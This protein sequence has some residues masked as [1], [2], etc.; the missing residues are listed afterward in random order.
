MSAEQRDAVRAKWG[1][2][3]EDLVIGCVAN[4]R[5]VKALDLLV[6]A[7]EDVVAAKANA[8]LVLVGEGPERSRLE[9]MVESAGL[10]SRVVLHGRE[11]DGGRLQAAFDI[12][13]LTS[14]SEG[15][16]NAMLEAE[17]AG[18]P[19]VATDVGGMREVVLDEVT[20]LLVSS[21]DRTALAL[22]LVRLAD[23]PSLRER[24][25][26]AGRKHVESAFGM[27]RFVREFSELYRELAG[28]RARSAVDG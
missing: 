15:L 14:T 7:F 18:R 16:P 24:M 9:R 28:R 17:A 2:S 23:D 4:Y 22:A 6:A 11:A 21:G 8:R 10:G 13:A 27:D 12:A 25:G 19:V 5:S 1:A 20:G 3:R 26:G